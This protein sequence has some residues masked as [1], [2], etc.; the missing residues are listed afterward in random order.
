MRIL[1]QVWPGFFS[2]ALALL[3]FWGF[4]PLSRGSQ[5]TLSALALLLAGGWIAWRWQHMRKLRKAACGL[6]DAW[7]PPES[8]C[9]AVV[10]VCGDDEL[11]F[12]ENKNPG[13]AT[14]LVSAHFGSGKPV[15]DGPKVVR[16]APGPVMADIDNDGH[17]A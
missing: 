12:G 13:N 3:L 10:L 16:N 8:F 11:L 7:L 5:W 9:G 15:T 14:R 17:C 1:S 6:D 4:W 2:A